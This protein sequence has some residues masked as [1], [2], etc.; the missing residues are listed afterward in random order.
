MRFNNKPCTDSVSPF[1]A[2][3]DK[4]KRG[5]VLNICD[6]SLEKSPSPSEERAAR[7]G[8]GVRYSLLLPTVLM[9]LGWSASARADGPLAP[10]HLRIGG[11]EVACKTAPLA[12]NSETFIPLEALSAIGME[13]K[14]DKKGETAHVIMPLVHKQ[15][16]IAFARPNGKSMLALSEVARLANATI[17]R[18]EKMGRDNK[19]IPGSKGDTVYLL[20]RVTDVRLQ[21]NQI[22]VTTSFPVP[23]KVCM[24]TNEKPLRGYVDCVGA[25]VDEKFQ[26]APTPLAGNEKT[27]P[28]VRAAQ[29]SIDTARIVAELPD[30]MRV[31]EQEGNANHSLTIAAELSGGKTL[32]AQNGKRTEND[33]NFKSTPKTAQTGSAAGS[34]SNEKTS[35]SPKNG[36]SIAAGVGSTLPRPASGGSGDQGDTPPIQQ[37]G[38]I[39]AD[40]TIA[41]NADTSTGTTPSST[42]KNDTAPK[43]A[44]Q[45]SVSTRPSIRG[46]QPSRGGSPNRNIPIEVRGLALVPD[47]DARVQLDIATSGAAG[48]YI[49]Y[50]EGSKLAV[51]IPN[52]L[53]HL[54][55]GTSADQTLSHP[56]LSGIHAELVQDTPPLTRVTIDTS[57]FVGFTVNNQ[58]NKISV[59]LR[60]PRSAT[61][62]LADKVIVVDAGHGGS[63][64]GATAGGYQEKNITLQISLRLREILEAAGAKVVMTR[65]K[66]VDVNLYD[67]PYLANDINADL[68]VSIHN[69]SFTSESRGTSTY[70]H[71]SDSSS[72]ALANCVQQ[73]IV[74]VSG[75]PSKGAL[76]DGIL[77]NSGLAVLRASKMPAI[78]VEVA[79]ISN[80]Q[81]RRH[82]IDGSF[83]QRV[84]Q[85]IS[86]GLRQYVEGGTPNGGRRMNMP[87]QDAP[88]L[89]GDGDSSSFRIRE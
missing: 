87:L 1:V 48:T 84:A 21:N 22:H 71:M 52:A 70:Y 83:Q 31:K 81:D 10:I 85:A 17:V 88:P 30:G 59:E 24:I 74:A 34:K 73:A 49:H 47:G 54:P 26:P 6:S 69:D 77:Y 35:S 89:P 32:V 38:G 51:D 63:S 2:S 40:K 27:M 8:V 11:H 67:R 82:L 9:S 72:R 50:L 58:A 65:D 55:E 12:D 76:S 46:K 23:Y 29:Y 80:T 41:A 5:N 19:P 75:V 7:R 57:R 62:A 28:K 14:P 66:D 45:G 86:D 25:D 33:K 43:K 15:Q 16:D 20:A 79:Y 64:T 18:T 61:G 53:L 37:P 78:L 3:P 60:L 13:G 42:D 36:N 44:S 4:G 39:G 56:L 68:F